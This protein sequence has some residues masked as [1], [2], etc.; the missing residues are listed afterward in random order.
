MLYPTTTPTTANDKRELLIFRVLSRLYRG[1]EAPS[2]GPGR[3]PSSEVR[4][5]RRLSHGI[6]PYRIVVSGPGRTVR[7]VSKARGQFAAYVGTKGGVSVRILPGQS[8]A[9]MGW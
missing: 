9:T 8:G 4:A 5:C 2:P 6:G 1:V 3:P 7:R